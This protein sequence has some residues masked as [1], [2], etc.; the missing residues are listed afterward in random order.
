[1]ICPTGVPGGT[2][3]LFR[4]ERGIVV[5]MVWL[6]GR[7]AV[8]LKSQEAVTSTVNSHKAVCR[9][10]SNIHFLHIADSLSLCGITYDE[11]R[12]MYCSNKIFRLAID[13]E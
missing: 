2:D 8:G 5:F 13:P 6:C 12:I 1:M 11:K 3:N 10:S 9:R 4:P 7:L